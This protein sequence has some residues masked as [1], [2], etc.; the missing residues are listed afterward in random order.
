[1]TKKKINA[2]DQPERKKI[3]VLIADDHPIVRQSLKDLVNAQEDMEIIAEASNG[4]EAVS[5]SVELLPDIVIMDIG[6]PKM[7]GL[8]ATRRIVAHWSDRPRIVAMTENAMQGDR[9][10]CPA[11]GMYD[12]ISKPIKIR[13]LTDVLEKFSV[14]APEEE[15]PA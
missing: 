12:Y 9:E 7:N 11:S 5:L 2:A 14:A 15:T 6:M 10:L 1:M 8:E 13:E 4:Q 3:S